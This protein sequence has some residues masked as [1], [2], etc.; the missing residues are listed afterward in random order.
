MYK[1][2]REQN[3]GLYIHCEVGDAEA[4]VGVGMKFIWDMWI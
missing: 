4:G 1:Y 3:G 2:S